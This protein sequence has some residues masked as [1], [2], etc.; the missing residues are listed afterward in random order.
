MLEN[1]QELIERLTGVHSSKKSY[2]VDLKQK[3]IETAKRNTQ[4]EIINQL[5]QSIIVDMS[6]EEIMG[7]VAQKLQQVISFDRLSLY[8][9]EDDCLVLQTSVPPGQGI[10]PEQQKVDS[11]LSIFW[12]VLSQRRSFFWPDITTEPP[13]YN[14]GASLVAA[15]VRSLVALPL[16]SRE[17]VLGV[18]LVKSRQ[19]HAYGTGDLTFLQQ[20]ADQLAVCL[21]NANLYQ[22]V[23]VVKRQWEETF[24]AVSDLLIYLDPSYCLLRFNQAVPRFFKMDTAA[25][26]Q[27][28]C[29]ELFF[30]QDTPC[31]VCPAREAMQRN[32]RAYQQYRLPMGQTLFVSALPNKIQPRGG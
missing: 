12:P 24:E 20:L 16:L 23:L 14:E 19:P 13:T 4:L 32:T 30:Q 2:Y 28:H 26:A 7:Q 6:L 27:S 29:Y 25:I 15:G 22:E 17:A 1:R 3:I 31:L 8:I 5:A 21:N 9:L 18:L 11:P 10:L